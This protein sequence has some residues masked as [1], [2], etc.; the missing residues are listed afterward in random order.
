MVYAVG[1]TPPRSSSSILRTGC[2]DSWQFHTVNWL[3]GALGFFAHLPPS[4]V[5]RTVV[6]GLLSQRL[7]VSSNRPYLRSKREPWFILASKHDQCSDGARND[8]HVRA[9]CRP[10]MLPCLSDGSGSARLLPLW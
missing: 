2:S 4:H 7:K 1:R 10:T 3:P 6:V 8:P 5:V 9:W